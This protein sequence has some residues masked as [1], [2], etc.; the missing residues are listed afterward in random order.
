[1]SNLDNQIITPEVWGPHGW[2]FIHYVTLGYPENPTQIQKDK[3]Q[4]FFILLKDVLPCAL[5]ANHYKENL[6]HYPLNDQILSSRDKFIKWGIDI[7]NNVN[8]SK[9]KP[10][11]D[12]TT[13]YNM[14]NT[15]SECKSVKKIELF[16]TIDTKPNEP[17]SFESSDSKSRMLLNNFPSGK[18]VNEPYQAKLDK[19]DLSSMMI[20]EPGEKVL[21]F[22]SAR[23]KETQRVSS[24]EPIPNNN[25]DNNIMVY[26]LIGLFIIL[27]SIALIYKKY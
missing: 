21:T 19:L 7:H 25:I 1:M 3:Y 4:A 5:C 6:Q 20:N 26:K 24:N 15:D 13:A 17:S 12:Y 14:I 8:K 18:I 27:I 23:L 22:S 16:N 10:I 2:K 11:L 9:K